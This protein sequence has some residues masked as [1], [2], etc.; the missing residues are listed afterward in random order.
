MILTRRGPSAGVSARPVLNAPAIAACFAVLLVASAAFGEAPPAR[1]PID[2]LPATFFGVLPCADCK[3][4]RYQIEL[5]PDSRFAESVQRLHGGDN[6]SIEVSS[7]IWWISEDGTRLTLNYGCDPAGEE[8]FSVWQVENSR[9]LHPL[10]TPLKSITPGPSA[11]LTRTD[12]LPSIWEEKHFQFQASLANTRWVPRRMGGR[13]VKVGAPQH[14]P[15]IVLNSKD[16]QVTGSGGCNRITGSYDRGVQTLRM[17][18][19]AVTRMICPDLR[20]ETAFLKVLEQTWGY[21]VTGRRL[22]LLDERG[23]VLA[24]LEERNR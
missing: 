23:A 11:E 2:S 18:S 22:E 20:V 8:M 7:G 14:E 15:W 21:R 3:G 1:S 24:E 10:D 5:R 9:T 6:Q 16:R 12:S 17:R 19:L 4:I 13:A